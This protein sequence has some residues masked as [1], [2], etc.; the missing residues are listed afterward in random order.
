MF[1]LLYYS[2]ISCW[3]SLKD[4]HR[5]FIFV[6]FLLSLKLFKNEKLSKAGLKE[7][8]N[9]SSPRLLKFTINQRK[10]FKGKARQEDIVI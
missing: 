9:M 7:I 5:N 3:K 6:I 1:G 4:I 8:L 2:Y 10:R